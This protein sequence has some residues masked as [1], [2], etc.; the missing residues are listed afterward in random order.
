[1]KITPPAALAA[2]AAAPSASRDRP[3]YVAAATPPEAS[4]ILCFM[5]PEGYFRDAV[6]DITKRVAEI[7][8]RAITF[9][10]FRIAYGAAML[11]CYATPDDTPIAFR[12]FDC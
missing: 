10:V 1:M 3:A 2:Y 6:I 11:A 5:M 7:Y 4:N 9:T 8:R 12:L